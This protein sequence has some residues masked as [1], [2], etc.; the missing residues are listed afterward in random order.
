[1]IQLQQDFQ[2]LQLKTQE[3]SGKNSASNKTNVILAQKNLIK[4]Q[5]QRQNNQQKSPKA[6][7]KHNNFID[8]RG[9][10]S[11]P[12]QNAFATNNKIGNVRG[13]LAEEVAPES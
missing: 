7:T 4:L 11:T 9:S 13:D 12:S 3:S 8:L 1:L 5:T 6:L 10:T 2:S